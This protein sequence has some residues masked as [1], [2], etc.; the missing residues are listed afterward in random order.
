[1]V[2][3]G[4][5][6]GDGMRAEKTDTD[7]LFDGDLA[8][9]DPDLGLVVS[10]EAER[11]LEKLIFI[12]SESI[13]PPA[14]R[15]ALGSVFTNIYAE[16][17][18]S[19]R[20]L[21]APEEYL[22]DVPTGL[23]DHR[24]YG[25]RRYYKGT[26]FVNF[27]ESLA[28]RRVAELFA[29]ADDPAAAVRVRPEDVYANVQALSGAAA[30]NAVYAA[31]LEPGDTIMGL[32]LTQGGHLTHG[33]PVNRS[34]RYY[35]VSAYGVNRETGQIDYDALEATARE[36]NPKLIVAGGSA[37]P[38][39]VDWRRLRAIADG[40][41]SPA[42]VLADISHPAGLVVAGEFPNPIGF[43]DVVT[44]TTHKTMIG[45]RAAVI[46]T[47]SPELARKIDRAVFPG[48]QGGPHVN[49]IAAMA[50]A[51]NIARTPEF[52]RLQ[53]RIVENAR[54]LAAGLAARGLTL[55]YGGTSTHL[56]LVD[57]RA[58][59][60]EGGAPLNGDLASRILD[61]AGIV[62]NKNTIVGDTSAVYPGGLRLG[63]TW[64]TQRGLGPTEMDRVASLVHRILADVRTF[65][66]VGNRG[67]IPRGRVTWEA[68]EEVRAGV[69]ELVQASHPRP[70]APDASSQARPRAR[71][72]AGRAPSQPSESP[73]V[74]VPGQV[75]AQVGTQSLVEI[76][77]RRASAFLQGALAADVL[78]LGTGEA[79]PTRALWW[80]GRTLARVAVAKLPGDGRG[81]GYVVACRSED[82]AVLASW[83]E[84]LSDGY[85]VFDEADLLRKID[86]P[87]AVQAPATGLPPALLIALTE[88]LSREKDAVAAWKPYFVGQSSLPSPEAA[89]VAK[90]ELDFGA[91]EHAGPLRRTALHAEHQRLG[92]RLVPF[93]G[94]EMP[95]WYTSIAEE[96]R[97]VRVA[98]GLFD[99]AHMGVLEVSG[100]GAGRFLDLLTTN[101]VPAL[102]VG[103]AQYSYLLDPDGGVVDDI[104]IYRRSA[105]PGGERYLLVVNAVNA[106]KVAAWLKAA[107]SRE[108]VV[109]RGRPDREVDAQP[110]IRDLRDPSSGEDRRVD[111][112]LQGP[113]SLAVLEA[114]IAEPGFREAV[115]RLSRFE[116]VE[117]EVAGL[118][119]LVSRTGYT[120]ERLG[121]ELYVHP[122]RAVD[123]WRLLLDRGADLGLRPIG[124]GAR[125]SLRTEAGFPLYGH[126]LAGQHAISPFG[127]GYPGFVKLHKPFFVG[128]QAAIAAEDSRRSVVV[129]F[130]MNERGVRMARPGDPVVERRGECVGYV[131]S[132]AAVDGLQIG[133]AYV[134]RSVA[135]VGTPLGIFALG[136]STR[137]R[138]EKPKADLEPGDR[139]LIPEGATVVPRFM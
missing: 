74:Q 4:D 114:A 14:V 34:G 25:D 102:E 96:H 135:A 17:Y 15:Q 36:V 39:G 100:P 77:G 111:L 128:R 109:D 80:D 127:A 118:P 121:F 139:V 40:L 61:V 105:G 53:R 27:V 32:D 60:T 132:C 97:A 66:Y 99:L 87:V 104:L 78:G 1:M 49:N 122:E 55:A 54:A 82:A 28:Q 5:Q 116:L 106:E 71:L 38:W 101:Y 90:R 85:V 43:A 21:R 126:E 103:K 47:T 136:G 67:P 2:A 51:F 12:A 137:A 72:E 16:G 13:A 73:S 23:A 56:L 9:V 70:S 134:S 6:L 88:A 119:V 115:G 46:L 30:N 20:M 107:R 108:Y 7:F 11:Q 59:A 8:Q 33:S 92:A 3:I 68:L 63:T 89:K 35:R 48:E 123:L 83:L 125:D 10:L 26:D 50:V 41:R 133:L 117:G 131:T 58:I 44:F 52:R 65:Q 18:P 110:T 79:R 42:R 57:L 75:P 45:P 22:A 138:P 64:V 98:A 37:Y 112:A 29:T 69:R 76:R 19:R 31:L 81:D 84:A 86:G 62:C 91:H 120:G 24:R 124:L 113:R 130:R 95:V 93:A 94:W 129:R